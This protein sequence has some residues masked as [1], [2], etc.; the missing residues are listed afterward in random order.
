[1]YDFPMPTVP[2]IIFTTAFSNP[3]TSSA[4]T[5]YHALVTAIALAIF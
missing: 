5:L 1:M 3:I 4:M 2:T